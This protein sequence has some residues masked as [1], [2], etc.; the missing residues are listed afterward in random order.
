MRDHGHRAAFMPYMMGGFPTLETSLEIGRGYIAGGADVIELGVPYSDPLADGPVIQDAGTVAL[1]AGA[2]FAKIMTV[3]A[4][5]SAQVPVVI[6][7]YANIVQARGVVGFCAQLIEA[8]ASGDDRA[9][10][11][12]R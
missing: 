12:R 1:D 3:C 7:T 4:E 8:G 5:L 2:T 10:S 11:A 9:R 6:M